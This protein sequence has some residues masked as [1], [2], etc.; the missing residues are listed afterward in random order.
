MPLVS[1]EFMRAKS[2][3]TI[4]ITQ[5]H[6]FH[7][8][9]CKLQVV[10]FCGARISTKCTC[11]SQMLDFY[12][13]RL[14]LSIRNPCNILYPCN[15]PMRNGS[16]QGCANPHDST[17]PSRT[18]PCLSRKQEKESSTGTP[19]ISTSNTIPT[20]VIDTMTKTNHKKP[21]IIPLPTSKPTS[22]RSLPSTL[23]SIPPHPHR[24]ETHLT[25][26]SLT[27]KNESI[28][29]SRPPN[30]E[31]KPPHKKSPKR[32]HQTLHILH[33]RSCNKVYYPVPAAIDARVNHYTTRVLAS[34][35]PRAA[36]VQRASIILAQ[37][38]GRA[39]LGR[40]G[41]RRLYPGLGEGCRIRQHPLALT[42]E[43][44]S[45]ARARP[46]TH[47]YTCAPASWDVDFYSADWHCFSVVLCMRIFLKFYPRGFV[48]LVDEQD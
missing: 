35:F 11:A 20:V 26:H 36:V 25:T 12:I 22:I 34:F 17:V 45:R 27:T 30:E 3:S 29:S 24:P 7:T 46:S 18:A 1:H 38:K 32:A 23:Q 14:K 9:R 39:G 8:V 41:G 48:N 19:Q 40:G 42:A 10:R 13:L 47:A 33:A 31:P 6:R 4:G 15:S 2:K 44:V 37:R 21:I 28:S 16:T 43:A 5:G